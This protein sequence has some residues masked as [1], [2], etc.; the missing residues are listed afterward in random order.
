MQGVE[1]Y[2][3]LLVATGAGWLLGK[4]SSRRTKPRPRITQDIFNEYFVGLNYLLNGEPDE[5][6]DTF[7]KALEVNGET[8]QTHLALGALLR[9]RG[10]VDK[11]VKV[12]Q[13]LL[14][15]P[16]LES[17]LADASRAA[18]RPW[19]HRGRMY[20]KSRHLIKIH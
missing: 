2:V 18:S 13:A 17:R 8:I 11:A 15:R 9:R 12:H 3:L 14:A 19:P 1:I 20:M 10:E 7:I 16:G 4:I 6:I 5:A